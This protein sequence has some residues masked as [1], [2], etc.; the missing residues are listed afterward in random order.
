LNN[1]TDRVVVIANPLSDSPQID[2]MNFSNT[3]HGGAISSFG[4]LVSHDGKELDR[5]FSYRTLSCSIDEMIE[6][7]G[8]APPNNIKI[9][10]DGIEHLILSGAEKTLLRPEL[11]SILVEVNDDFEAQA[12]FVDEILSQSGF[13]LSEKRHSELIDFDE[14]FSRTFNQIWRKKA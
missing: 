8:L 1:L 9:D 10:V 14:A 7:W 5:V 11:I 13:E 4:T 6:K 2:S 3:L 12:K